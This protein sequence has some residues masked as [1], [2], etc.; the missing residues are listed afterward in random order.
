M[1]LLP[2]YL[3]LFYLVYLAHFQNFFSFKACKEFLEAKDLKVMF[4]IIIELCERVFFIHPSQDQQEEPQQ[5]NNYNEKIYQLPIFI[6]SLANIC[7]QIDDRLPEGNISTLEK[8]IILTIE[9]YP[10]LNRKNDYQIIIGLA[11][12]FIAIQIRKSE[13]YPDFVSRIVYQSMIR[14]FSYKT[15]YFFQQDQL[16]QIILKNENTEEEIENENEEKDLFA[17]KCTDF[18]MLWSNLLNI[19]ESK[20]LNSLGIH[21]NDRKKLVVIIYDSYIETLIKIVNKLDLNSV[22]LDSYDEKDNNQNTEINLSSNP[23]AGLRPT[24]PKDLEILINLV[25]FSR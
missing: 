3:I 17:I 9:S 8:L 2:E 1:V 13:L 4:N 5:I 22:K 21:I 19:T 14:I 7:N 15:N 10:R 12:L 16:E 25:D 11:Q 20:E 24:K 6:E 18:V 23:V